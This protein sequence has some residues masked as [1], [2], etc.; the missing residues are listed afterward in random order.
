MK[1]LNNDL[2]V[3]AVGGGDGVRECHWC[4][5]EKDEP[6]LC[7]YGNRQD[8]NPDFGVFL[9]LPCIKKELH[10]SRVQWD[11]IKRKAGKK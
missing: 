4:G 3:K 7:V 9:C 2:V 6:M 8:S 5:V 10:S 1:I 11:E